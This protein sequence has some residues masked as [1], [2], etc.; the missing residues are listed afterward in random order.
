MIFLAWFPLVRFAGASPHHPSICSALYLQTLCL[1]LTTRWCLASCNCQTDHL[2]RERY[3]YAIPP[4]G[5]NL[6]FFCRTALNRFARRGAIDSACFSNSGWM[7]SEPAA[8]PFFSFLIARATSSVIGSRQAYVK[9]WYVWGITFKVVWYLWFWKCRLN[10]T[11]K[12]FCRSVHTPTPF[13]IGHRRVFSQKKRQ[14][15]W[16]PGS[17]QKRC[18]SFAA[19]A[20]E[21]EGPG[22]EWKREREWL[23]YKQG[24]LDL[25]LETPNS[26]LTGRIA[27]SNNTIDWKCKFLAFLL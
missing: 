3:N 19:A 8:L 17:A 6:L 23:P 12:K 4:I 5:G 14:N 21:E 10:Q 22:V 2:F 9:I 11:L 15:L 1:G 24:A 25:P 26:C 13:W 20:R 16:R 18:G 27:H 7:W